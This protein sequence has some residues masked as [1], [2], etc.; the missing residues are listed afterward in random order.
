MELRH[1]RYFAAV[2]DE[3]HFGRAAERL[4]ISGPTLT[5]QIKALENGLRVRLF[6]RKTKRAV[7]LTNAGARFLEEARATIRQAELAEQVG[8]QA[9]LGQAGTIT[10]GYVL[11]ASLMG[12]L[13]SAVASFRALHPTVTFEVRRTET[14]ATMRDIASGQ[15]DVGLLR[16]PEHFPVGLTGFTL[17]EDEFCAIL[18]AGHPLAKH[19]RI[20]AS[21]LNDEDFVATP[22][23]MEISFWNN[24]VG[25]TA[26]RVVAR[27]NDV[28][29]VLT[30]VAGGVGISVLPA[31][32]ANVRVPGIVFRTMS[33]VRRKA[34]YSAV[35]RVGEASPVI[36]LF[37]KH[38]RSSNFS[39]RYRKMSHSRQE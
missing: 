10:V 4:N 8:R 35:Y 5:N 39:A 11:T 3:L 22:M 25:A 16:S 31:H 20:T 24:F 15:T 23:E 14:L 38:L 29:S 12:L 2:A 36:K 7:T 13:P 34:S 17:V 30:L 18:P 6:E 37:I 19:R 21:M 9:G 27:A 1:L 33:G 32:V 26:R 28:V